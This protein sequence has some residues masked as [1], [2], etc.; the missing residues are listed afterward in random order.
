LKT[1]ICVPL[2]CLPDGFSC[3]S[4]PLR[5]SIERVGQRDFAEIMQEGYYRDGKDRLLGCPHLSCNRRCHSAH[6]I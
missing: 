5:A 3:T 1:A 2:L 6:F 4:P